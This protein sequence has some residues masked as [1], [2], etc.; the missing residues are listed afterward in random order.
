MSAIGLSG[1][2]ASGFRAIGSRADF[3]PE[4]F[5]FARTQSRALRDIKWESRIKPLHSW[6]EIL[7]YVAG[8]IVVT[9]ALL[10]FVA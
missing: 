7:L 10:S 2:S 6:S 9:V 3:R 4:H 8:G 1:G 5:R